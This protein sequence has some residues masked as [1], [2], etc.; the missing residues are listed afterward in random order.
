MIDVVLNASAQQVI[1]YDISGTLLTRNGNRGH[2]FAVQNV[3]ACEGEERWMAITIRDDDDWAALVK[4]LG[5][6]EWATTGRFATESLRW[7]NAD[8]IDERL[9]EW[10]AGQPLDTAVS[11]LITAGIPAAP[12]VTPPSV[13]DNPALQARG[14]FEAISHPLCGPLPYPRPPITTPTGLDRLIDR[15]APLLGEHNSAILGGLLGLS[16]QELADLEAARV[17][18]SSPLTG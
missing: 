13:L 17:I 3:Y 1:E 16:A 18:G 5:S 14:F 6:P 9:A 7:D 2:R 15:P 12:V 4:V 8:F 11:D 10:F